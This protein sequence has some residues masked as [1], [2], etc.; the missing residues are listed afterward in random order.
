MIT[1]TLNRIRKHDPCERGWKKLL[2]H[3]GKTKADN[4]PLPLVTILESNGLDDALWCLRAVDR[5]DR[6]MRLY[7]V[8]CA[9]RVQHL[10]KSRRSIKALDVAERYANGEATDK[11][12]KAGYE[13]A[14]AAL[15][16]AWD[17][18]RAKRAAA[19]S[20]WSCTFE[21]ACLAAEF[22]ADAARAAA[23]ETAGAAAW[24]AAVKAER[25]WQTKEFKR[26]FG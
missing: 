23:W 12:L 13:A 18:A 19:N 11:E 10:M 16:A 17:A 21:S 22:A 9:R 4:K 25:K 8:A 14:R 2:E 26:R 24:A 5:H 6:E 1:T 3:L 7:A 15:Y 20:A